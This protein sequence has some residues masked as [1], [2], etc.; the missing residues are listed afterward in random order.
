MEDLIS[1]IVPVYNNINDIEKCLT[2]IQNQTYGNFE[3]ILIDDGSTDGSGEFIDK[4]AESDNRFKVFH[5][6]NGGVSSARNLG[7]DN[8]S[9]AWISFVDGDDQI[10]PVYLE[11]LHNALVQKDCKV[12]VCEMFKSQS[13]RQSEE[14]RNNY[15]P[16]KNH[17]TIVFDKTLKKTFTKISTCAVGGKMYG[18]DI[19]KDIRFST[20]VSFTEDALFFS[21]S[22]VN[23]NKVVYLND[24]LY[25]YKVYGSNSLSRHPT[26]ESRFSRVGKIEKIYKHFK[27]KNKYIYREFRTLYSVL[28]FRDFTFIE[29]QEEV[30]KHKKYLVKQLRKNVRYFMRS[31]NPGRTKKMYVMACML[32]NLFQKILKKKRDEEKADIKNG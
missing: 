13:K 24:T 32:P 9:G 29:M 2:S 7:L 28:C 21:D 5:K 4:F 17:E 16:S 22:L 27:G 19:V 20:D 15:Q 10:V 3:C 8:A 14:H 25:I 1:V 11:E 6:E 12:A 31:H 26:P 30:L 18:A 23:V